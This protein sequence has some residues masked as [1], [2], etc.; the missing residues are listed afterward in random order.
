M[1]DVKPGPFNP[2]QSDELPKRR[3]LVKG[4]TVY[5]NS[6]PAPWLCLTGSGSESTLKTYFFTNLFSL[7]IMPDSNLGHPLPALWCAI[8]QPSATFCGRIFRVGPG[9]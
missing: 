8:P 7:R 3:H 4:I 1:K 6:D 9:G 5:D 2:K